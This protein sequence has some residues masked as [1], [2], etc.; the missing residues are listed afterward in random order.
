MREIIHGQMGENR[1]EAF[2]MP[3]RSQGSSRSETEAE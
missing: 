2:V 1:L 3:L